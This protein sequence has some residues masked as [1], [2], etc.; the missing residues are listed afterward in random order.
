MERAFFLFEDKIKL[1]ESSFTK[2]GWITIYESN[3]EP[4]D[5][6]GLI[7]CC[8]VE[9][10]IIDSY[11][12]TS[13]WIIEPGSEGKPSIISSFKDNQWIS[14]YYSNS[15]DGIEPFIFSKRFTYNGGHEAYI[16]IS[17]EF[18]LYFK[19]YEKS[20]N[21]QNRVLYFIDEIGDLDEAI[22]VKN[23]SIRVKL[24]YLI[25]YI[26]VRRVYF[27]ICFDFMRFA[28][29]DFKTLDT[30][31]LDQNY[32]SSNYFF[33]HYIRSVNDIKSGQLQS[34]IHGKCLLSFDE[35][36]SNKYYFDS[37]KLHESFITGYND[38]GE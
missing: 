23:N 14:E 7:Y 27:S 21:K 36:K 6:S 30:K 22:V 33:N 17:E 11:R 3:T 10:H 20:A 32:S 8:I 16:D 34:W 9:Q 24:K 18:I 31:S 35:S 12:S 29:T 37:D 4:N 28:E 2:D 5:S 19:L 38:N 25:E 13:D 1:I 15:N 26:S